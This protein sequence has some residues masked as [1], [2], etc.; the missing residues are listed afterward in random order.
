MVLQGFRNLGLGARPTKPHIVAV[1]GDIVSDVTISGNLYRVHIFNASGTFQVKSIGPTDGQVEYLIVGGGGGGGQQN[2]GNNYGGGGGGGG[3][4]YRSNVAG[5]TSGRNTAAEA[6][7]YVTP[8]TIY[9]IVVGNGGLGATAVARGETGGPS[10]FGGI[11]AS[12]GG[13]GAGGG[14][15]GLS[16]GSGGGGAGVANNLATGGGSGTAA[17]GYNGSAGYLA[18]GVYTGGGAG[19]GAGSQASTNDSGGVA[20]VG[21]SS[22]ITGTS[23][24]RGAGARGV[25]GIGSGAKGGTSGADN[26]GNG[27]EGSEYRTGGTGSSGVVIIRYRLFA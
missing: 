8:Q 19:G 13:G 26:L 22:N 10:S 17:Q 1:G 16:G 4:G 2:S 24:V 20:G 14:L 25:T 21:L 11:S 15:T 18:P 6:P 7:F 5:Q 3:G 12:G 9:N 23:V 27:G